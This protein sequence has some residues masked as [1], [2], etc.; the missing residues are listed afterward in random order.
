MQTESSYTA[1]L[2]VPKPKHVDGHHFW[3]RGD[4]GDSVLITS[5]SGVSEEVAKE[6]IRE[7]SRLLIESVRSDG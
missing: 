4:Y 1:R 3:V 5:I 7:F 2:E 6:Q